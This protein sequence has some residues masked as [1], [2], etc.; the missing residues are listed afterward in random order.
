MAYFV[1]KGFISLVPVISAQK[2]LKI[3]AGGEN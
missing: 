1:K 3:I 2:I